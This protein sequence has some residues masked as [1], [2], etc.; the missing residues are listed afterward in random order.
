[1][2]KVQME[3]FRSQMLGVIAA[4]LNPK[5][6]ADVGDRNISRWSVLDSAWDFRTPQERRVQAAEKLFDQASEIL[7]AVVVEARRQHDAYRRLREESLAVT[8]E[9]S[10]HDN[11][12]R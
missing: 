3:D 6:F 8:R 10:Q 2:G 5:L 4:V 7:D 9:D 11:T 12:G 1:M